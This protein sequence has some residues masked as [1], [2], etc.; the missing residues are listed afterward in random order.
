MNFAALPVDGDRY[1]VESGPLL[2]VLTTEKDLAGRDSPSSPAC[3]LMA[4]GGPDFDHV[5]NGTT[6]PLP[7]ESPSRFRST[8]SCEEFRR[9]AFYPL[10]HAA[11]E[12]E[13]VVRLWSSHRRGTT[14]CPEPV[15][16]LRGAE[17][18]E[19]AFKNLAPGHLVLHLAT[20]GFFL[21]DRCAD[22]IGDPTASV[23]PE[24]PDHV[25]DPWSSLSGLVLAGANRRDTPGTSEDDGILTAGEIA[26]LPLDG[27]EWVVLSACETGVGDVRT[28]EGVF[29][30]RR[31]FRIAGARTLIMSLWPVEDRDA[32][33]WMRAVYEARL[34][35]RASTA[36]AVRRATLAMLESRRSAGESTLPS[37]WA[38][39]V[40]AGDWR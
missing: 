4:L 5:G 23:V 26:L 11:E 2:H 35:G 29:G 10:P 28:G 27:V 19:T 17:A 20:H 37:S 32:R 33:A 7:A 25:T 24:S 22:G 14:T 16:L 3:G 8:L 36:E 18:T 40:A 21:A 9:M 39:F 15:S 6:E 31:A 12:A 34:A 1:L 13:E 38:G 30:M